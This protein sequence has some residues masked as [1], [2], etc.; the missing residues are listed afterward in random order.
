MYFQRTLKNPLYVGWKAFL[1]VKVIGK[2][3]L[4]W[5]WDIE[6]QPPHSLPKVSQWH[7]FH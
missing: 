1:K 5:L 7:E 2:P 4:L 6:F 3:R